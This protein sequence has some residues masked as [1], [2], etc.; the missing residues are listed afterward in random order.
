MK[1]SIPFDVVA[2]SSSIKP[3]RS[4]F[5]SDIHLGSRFARVD[6]LLDLLV[7]HTP[8]YL[9][10]VGD[11]VDGWCL[12]RRW[13]WPESYDRLLARLLELA[14]E[15]TIIRL[16]PGNH[17]D[18]LRRFL[19]SNDL[20]T[21]S[22]EFVHEV[23]DSRKLLVLHGD[24][25][26]TVERNAPWLSWIGGAGYELLMRIDHWCN[27]L[28]GFLGFRRRR[29]SQAIKQQVKLV[30]QFVSGFE[31]RAVNY[32]RQ[33]GCDIVACG[34]IHYPTLIQSDDVLYINLGDWVENGTALVEHFDGSLQLIDIDVESP[35]GESPSLL[36]PSDND[37]MT[38][39]APATASVA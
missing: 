19:L 18:F 36:A 11:I 7:D 37:S 25:F 10:L 31:E 24:T 21:I 35:L 4:L 2:T 29:I 33:N 12:K 9:Y 26:D 1:S 15:G 32:A 14:N 6:R 16:T 39:T 34:H 20:V 28:L 8:T 5:V 22:N 17:D 30:V 13:H 23:A 38:Y 27:R 3:V